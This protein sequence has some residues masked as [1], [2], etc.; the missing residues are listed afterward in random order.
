MTPVS[1]WNRLYG[2]FLMPSRLGRYRRLLERFLRAGYTVVSV[3]QFWHLSPD[4]TAPPQHYL[5]LRH[6]VDTDPRTAAAMWD[7]ERDLGIAGS[8]YFRLSTVDVPLMQAIASSGGQ[9]S[10]H[11][12]ELATLAKHRGIRRRE[13]AAACLPEARE[14]FRG[15][16]ESLRAAT[17]LPMRVVASH[18]DFVNRK[19][20]VPNTAILA[21]PTFRREVGINLETY[22]DAFMRRVSSRH[23]DTGPPRH[24]TPA[25]P[26]L[27]MASAEPV[28]Y[29][30]VHP[31]HWRASPYVN[32]RDDLTRVFEG[33][34]YWLVARGWLGR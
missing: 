27:A 1:I 25:D 14:L 4:D 29:V 15:N 19:L 21:E 34:R 16:L 22:D 18:G 23:S 26:L 28:I 9:A 12:E 8:F 3:E 7:I 20:R 5:I 11:Y 10:Y 17:G 2:D 33:V 6:D 31:R 30:L 24:W 13:D 32:A